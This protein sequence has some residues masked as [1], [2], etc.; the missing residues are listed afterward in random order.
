M[1]PVVFLS[2]AVLSADPWAFKPIDM[3]K[4][5]LDEGIVFLVEDGEVRVNGRLVR[6]V[7]LPE[8]KPGDKYASGELIVEM[9]NK[10]ERALTPRLKIEVYNRYGMVLG[11]FSVHWTLDTV[12]AGATYSEHGTGLMPS[13]RW[14]LRRS[15]MDLPVDVDTPTYVVIVDDSTS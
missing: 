1:F 10:T 13:V 12:S 8:I 4:S 5:K 7:V 14:L 3:T 9:K 11:D 6:R 15:S 2:V